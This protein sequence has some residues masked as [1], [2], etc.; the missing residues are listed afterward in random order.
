MPHV[1]LF[2]S[3]CMEL[4]K[5]T[6]TQ[7][8]TSVLFANDAIKIQINKRILINS[9]E[10][11]NRPKH[12]KHFCKASLGDSCQLMNVNGTESETLLCRLWRLTTSL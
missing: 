3:L 5:N 10:K 1:S 2:P 6:H 11:S 4:K 8:D 9:S 7:Y 12:D